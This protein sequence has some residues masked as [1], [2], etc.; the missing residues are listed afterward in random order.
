M[1]LYTFTARELFYMQC[2]LVSSTALITAF[3]VCAV[4]A[5]YYFTRKKDK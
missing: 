2:K 4:F 3:V 1:N 5:F